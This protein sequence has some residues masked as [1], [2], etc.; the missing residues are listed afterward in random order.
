MSAARLAR[1]A[2]AGRRGRDRRRRVARGAPRAARRPARR[3]RRT[4]WSRCRAGAVVP[5]LTRAE[6]AR[7]RRRWPR[8]VARVLGSSAA[9]PAG[10]AGVPDRSRKVSLL[11][12][13]QVPPRDADLDESSAGRCARARRSRSSRRSAQRE[14]RRAAADGGREFVVALARARRHRGS[15]SRRAR[16]PAR[17][18]GSSTSRRSMSSTACSPAAARRRATGCSCTWPATTSPWRVRGEHLI[19]FRH[20]SGR[21]GH[22]RRPVHQTAMY[23]E[24]RLDG[25]GFA[26]VL[27]AGRRGGCGRRPNA[28][29]ATRGAPRHARRSA[30]IRAPRPRWPIAS[31]PSPELL[32]ALAPLVGVLR[33]ER[34]LPDAARPTSRPG[35]STTSAPSRVT[36]AGLGLLVLALTAFNVVQVLSRLRRATRESRDRGRRAPKRMRRDCAPRPRRIR[37]DDQS[38]SARRRS[39][40]AA[41]E[42]NQL[43][44]RR[45][46]SWTDLFNRFE[47]TLPGGRP[48]RVGARRQ[49]ISR[50]R[51]LSRSPFARG[52]SRTSTGSSRR[53]RRPARSRSPARGRKKRRRTARSGR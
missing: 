43:I 15:T 2:A 31:A 30:S 19:F 10:G 25:A 21:R 12:L 7:R 44:D 41:H 28:C 36:L 9:A 42:A 47:A 3:R 13:E 52:A 18:P 6:H 39:Q 11:R 1:D 40:S 53:S 20:R 27:L 26:R 46:F 48:H 34:G 5:S 33:R 49:S 22:A 32:D 51:M 24:D 8:R 50:A 29:A 17:T 23:Y 4:P 35:R 37:R 16:R 45:A 38:R 14:S